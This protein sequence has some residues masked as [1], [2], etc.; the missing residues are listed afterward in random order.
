MSKK[1]SNSKKAVFFAAIFASLFVALELLL[2]IFYFVTVGDFI[3]RRAVPSIYEADPIRCYRVKPNL[4]YAHLTNE[5]E[6][7]IYTDSIGLRSDASHRGISEEKPDD[8]YRIL[9]TGPSF[10][11][12]W[13]VDYEEAYAT[14]IEEGLAIPDRR[15]EIMNLGTPSQGPAHQLCWL[16]AVGYRYK[17][18][19]VFHTSYGRVVTARAADCPAKLE[20]P[21][22][23]NGQLVPREVSAEVRF[24]AFAKRFGTVFYAYYAYNMIVRPDPEPDPSKALHM[25]P[26]ADSD[27]EAGLE[28][29]VQSYV[30]YEEY[31][32]STLGAGTAVAFLYLP[33]SYQV[34]TGD[35]GRF[36]DVHAEDIPN[37]R[38]Q[39]T[40]TIRR[41]QERGVSILNALP[42]LLDVADRERLYYWLD[43]HLTPAGNRVIA[44]SAIPFLR[45]LILKAEFSTP[46]MHR[47][48]RDNFLEPED[49]V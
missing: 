28:T 27:S 13:A 24:K 36:T 47:T 6:I 23:Q 30:D 2:Q 32:K 34:H 39:I 46:T 11:F 25:L 7:K 22:I 15:I 17:P 44:E 45:E 16:K 9:I 5:F 3:F 41:L 37:G 42:P 35:I 26:K 29:I 49:G 14:L 8:V 40:E 21:D 31:V 1:I 20:C 4:E 18:D 12:G 48:E 38:K 10:A 19:M 43:I 33:Y